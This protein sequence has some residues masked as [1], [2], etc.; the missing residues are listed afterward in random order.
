[1][2]RKID[3]GGARPGDKLHASIAVQGATTDSPPRSKAGGVYGREVSVSTG[4]TV[5]Q[6]LNPASQ[7]GSQ[8]CRDLR[9]L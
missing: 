6:L 4:S 7:P 3:G 5:L 2:P 1:M 9:I 8:F